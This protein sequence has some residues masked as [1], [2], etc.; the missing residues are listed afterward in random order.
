VDLG[1]ASG[2]EIEDRLEAIA[3]APGVVFDMRGYPSDHEVLSHLLTS[4]DTSKGWMQV[5]RI[6]YPDHERIAGWSLAG[7]ELPVKPPHIRGKVAFITGGMAISYAESFLS[8]VE[9]YRLG[10]IVGGPTAGANGNVSSLELPGG[11]RIFWT[12]M[13]VVKHDGS[14]HH[15]VGIRPTVKAER[16]LEG[17]RE[18]RDELLERAL[19]LVGQAD[20]GR[21][22]VI[23]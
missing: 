16:T 1:R 22:V 14:P 23:P 17:V 20:T 10:E 15:V 19:A 12:G 9:H 7:W 21:P 11:Y 8:F 13:R 2:K 5:P 3:G 18:G 6:I 4:P